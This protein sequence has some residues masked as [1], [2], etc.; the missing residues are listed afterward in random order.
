MA[1]P[2]AV[3]DQITDSVTQTN[4]KVLGE[5]PEMALGNLYQVTSQALAT[6]SLNAVQNQQN[7]HIL[8]NAAIASII[9]GFNQIGGLDLK[10]TG[11]KK[12]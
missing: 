6:A 2:T 12:T 10:S 3:N 11:N 7:S 8:T 1:Y 9:S 5:A 4:T